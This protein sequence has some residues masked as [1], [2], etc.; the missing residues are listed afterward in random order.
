MPVRR[1][2]ALFGFEGREPYP[3]LLCACMFRRRCHLW[4]RVGTGMVVVCRRLV[5]TLDLSAGCGPT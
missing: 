3:K 2:E 1:F 5:A 4:A